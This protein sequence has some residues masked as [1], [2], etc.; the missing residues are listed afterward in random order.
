M[1]LTS[2]K[3]QMKLI[4]C[5]IIKLIFFQ[6][7][8]IKDNTKLDGLDK[9]CKILINFSICLKGGTAILIR[10]NSGLD[11]LNWE[12]DVNGMILNAKCKYLSS[13]SVSKCICT[14]GFK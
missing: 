14:F 2:Q 6:E 7:H 4:W 12:A 3:K 13:I 1:G 10:N 11:D 5:F 9:C 8:N